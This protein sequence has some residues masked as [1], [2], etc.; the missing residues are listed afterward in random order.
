MLQKFFD[1]FFTINSSPIGETL[2]FVI[3]L[4]LISK[5]FF[6]YYLIQFNFFYELHFTFNDI[7]FEKKAFFIH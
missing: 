2:K 6:V 5:H 7:F 3:N 1:K 4:I